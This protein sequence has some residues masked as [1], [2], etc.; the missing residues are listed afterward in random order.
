[1]HKGVENSFRPAGKPKSAKKQIWKQIESGG[2]WCF[3]LF[4]YPTCDMPPF[5]I[6]LFISTPTFTYM[7]PPFHTLVFTFSLSKTQFI[8]WLFIKLN[9]YVFKTIESLSNLPNFGFITYQFLF[10]FKPF[11]L[12]S[13]FGNKIKK[14]PNLLLHLSRKITFI[15]IFWSQFCNF[16]NSK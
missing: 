11:D 1:M 13:I 9:H 10:F 4:G 2:G 8:D 16:F 5:F 3:V 14:N 6:S 12:H 15:L 7:H